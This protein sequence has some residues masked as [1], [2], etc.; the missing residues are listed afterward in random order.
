ME[1]TYAID[2]RD[3]LVGADTGYF[4]FAEQNQWA[5]AEDSIGESL[6]DFV[7]DPTLRTVQ[8]SLVRRIR[9]TG[10]GV[11][12][13]FRCDGPTIR[14]EMT[15]AIRPQVDAGVTFSTRTTAEQSRP[16][17][18][19]LDPTVRRDSNLVEMCSWCD[20]FFVGGRWVE[21]EE[22]AAELNLMVTGET[23]AI[24]HGL[25]GRCGERLSAP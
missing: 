8:K 16:R 4:S 7:A 11:E 20:R 17:Q 15:I 25:C 2:D 12:L 13:P 1:F 10:Q 3:R 6:W 21:V 24:T 22:A 23:P 18:A 9:A 14:R 19:L 5:G